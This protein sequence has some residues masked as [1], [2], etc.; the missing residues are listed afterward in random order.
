MSQAELA[1]RIGLRDA[2]AV[3]HWI[4]DS[5]T[6]EFER[7]SQIAG[8]FEMTLSGLLSGVTDTADRAAG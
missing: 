1:R 2:S 3:S 8:V 5:W 6:P 7:L 4:R